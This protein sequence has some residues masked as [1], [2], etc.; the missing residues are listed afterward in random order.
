MFGTLVQY[1]CFMEF[2]LRRALETFHAEKMLPKGSAKFWPESLPDSKLT[3][4]LGAVVKGMDP[5]KEKI[6]EA[7]V[8][9]Q[10]IDSTRL[11]RNLVAHF[12][13]KRHNN[14]VRRIGGRMVVVQEAAMCEYPK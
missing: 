14:H 7:L 2:N 13:G 1:F 5:A 11:K 3:E 4:A 8:W 12:A 6:E 9:L 10:V